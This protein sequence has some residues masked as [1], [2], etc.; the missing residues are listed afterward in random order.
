LANAFQSLPGLISADLIPTPMRLGI[1]ARDLSANEA[2]LA[3]AAGGVYI[4]GVDAGSLA[5]QMGVQKGD[6]LLEV[7]GVKV[8][9]QEA[10]KKQLATGSIKTAVVWRNGKILLLSVLNKF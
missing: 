9:G 6:Y 2:K 7:D 10:M 1:S 3:G 4:G 8:P 5:E